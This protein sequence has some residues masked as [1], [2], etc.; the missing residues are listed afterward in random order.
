MKPR[1]ALWMLALSATMIAAV[2]AAGAPASHRASGAG[3]DSVLVRV[4]G[5]TIT[6][7]S[8]QRRIDDLPEN[9]RGQFTSPEGRQRLLDRLVEERIWLLTALKHGV[10]DRPE[11][12][13]Q[14]EQ[15]RRDLLIR[16]Y[17]NEL[18]AANPAPSDSEAQVWYDAHAADYKTPASV[19]LSHIMVKTEAEGKKVRQWA[20][21]GQDW[22]KLVTRYSTDSLTRDRGGSLGPTTREGVLGHLG[23]Q[24]AMAET[25]FAIGKGAIGGPIRSDRGWH[26]IKVDDF[27]PEGVRSFD[28]VRGSILRQISSRHSQDFYQAQLAE[29]RKTLAVRADS[30]TIHKY[31]SQK[32][33]AREMFN[34]AQL[35]GAPTA[36]IEAYRKLVEEHPESEVS[37][38]AAFMIGFIQSEEIKDYSA[39]EK[40][41]RDLLQ[42]YPK[43]ELAASARWML[44][45]MRN[46]NAP[47][48][49]NLESDSAKAAT[50]APGGGKGK[51]KT[52]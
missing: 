21:A 34:E 6:T 37:P 16:T 43:S 8:L 52:P 15:Q 14:I 1:A 51:S 42:R 33:S 24:P 20:R 22:A 35:A 25:A 9:V 29:A 4:G 47:E 5:E 39:A 12:K 11:I 32:K 2:P 41:F 36:R 38:Q 3:A 19:T 30:N 50:P 27:K 10:A 13:K 26:V 48:F 23:P 7:G 40:S 45:H 28:Q 44:D 18:M 31:L 49:M 46:E 17:I